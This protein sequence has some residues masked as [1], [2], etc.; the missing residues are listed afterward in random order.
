MSV[1]IRTLIKYLKLIE[2]EDYWK[3]WSYT[4]PHTKEGYKRFQGVLKVRLVK[5]VGG[6]SLGIEESC[7]YLP[8]W[9]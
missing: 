1:N 7:H 6:V 8:T 9:K 5:Y 2:I 3:S 4:L